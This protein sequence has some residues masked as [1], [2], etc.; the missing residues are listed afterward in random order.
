MRPCPWV[1]CRYHLALEVHPQTGTIT[2][3]P[4]CDAGSRWDIELD[5]ALLPE[6]CALDV[7]AKGEHTLEE[8]GNLVAL[9]QEAV[10][11]YLRYRRK[12]AR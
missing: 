4:R 5:L 2:V 12:E 1:S 8:V 11:P 7:A 10:A 3:N 6:S 9:T